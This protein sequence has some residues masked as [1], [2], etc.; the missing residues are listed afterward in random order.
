MGKK[1]PQKQGFSKKMALMGVGMGLGILLFTGIAGQAVTINVLSVED[2]FYFS[3][4]KALPEFEK[5]T[6]IK[7]SLQPLAYDAL[8][9]KI[10]ASFVGRTKGIDVVTVDQMWLSQYAENRW[11]TALTPYIERDKEAVRMDE[12]VPETIYTMSEW[13]GD[14][15]TLPIGTYGQFVMYRTDLLEKTG[16]QP[17]PTEPAKWWTWDQ[18][19]DYVRKLDA[20][21][22]EIYG[23]VICGAQPVPIVHMY[24]QL[25]VSKGVQWFKQFPKAPWDFTPTINSGENVEALKY[26]KQ[27]YE[28][29]P[30]ESINYNWF[31]AG[32]SFAKKDIGIFFWWTPYGY[33]VRQAGYMVEEPSPI[34]GKYKIALLPHQPGIPQTYSLGGWSLAVPTYSANKEEAWEFVKWATSKRIQKAMALTPI[35]QFNDFAREPLFRDEDCLKHYPWLSTQLYSLKEGDGKITRP[36]IP[37]YTTLEGFYGLQLNMAVAGLKTPEMAL[38][39][40]QSQFELALKQNFYLPFKMTSYDDTLEKITEL[41][42]KLS[43]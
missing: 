21:G 34:V 22:E 13:R 19:M 17:P 20:L 30:G 28:H 38:A 18:Y 27:L 14:I 32:M 2:P 24:T 1:C 11:I 10:I 36:P 41:I 16:L 35:Y 37:I 31:D 39:D 4:E 9:A 33:L 23:T 42:G 29:S 6:G 26:Y 15:Y 12:F 5:E 8:H 43:P 7:V 25:A 40:A 3:L